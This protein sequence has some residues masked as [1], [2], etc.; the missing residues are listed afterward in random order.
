MPTDFA[1]LVQLNVELKLKPT[2]ITWSRLE[3]LALSRGDLTPGLQALLGDP[4]WLLGRQ[5]QFEELRGEDAGS[6]VTVTVR[7]EQAGVNRFHPGPFVPGGDAA[8]A[9][10]DVPDLPVEVAVEAEMPAVLPE[11]IRAEGG[12][13]L[14]RLVAVRGLPDGLRAALLTA[15]AFGAPEA[16]LG[17]VDPVGATRRRLLAGRVPDA[18]RIADDLAPLAGPDGALGGLPA[19]LAAASAGHE[20]AVRT[21]LGG[22][23]AGYRGIVAQPVGASWDPHRLEYAFALQAD[24]RDGPAVLRA[25]EYTDGRLDWYAFDVAATPGLGAPAAA[26]DPRPIEETVI[27]SPV[28]YAGMPSD[29]LWQ[30]EDGRVYLGG[31]EAGPTDLSRLA[32]TEFALV[33]GNDWYL[34]PV[35]MA[36]GS[37]VRIDSVVVRDTFGIETLVRPARQAQRP[38]WTVFHLAAH[39]EAGPLA[40]VFVLPATVRSVLESAPLEEVALFRDEMANL[41]W[42]VERVVQGPTGEPVPWDRLAARVSLRQRLPDDLGDA[43]LVYR[44]MTPVPENWIPF[45]AVPVRGQPAGSRATELERQPM[46]RFLDDGTT[47][48]VHPRGVVLRTA[49]DADVRTDRLRVAEEEVPRD[50]AVVTR[51]YQLARTEGGGTL[52]WIGRAKQAGQGEGASGL[53][54]DTALPPG[55]L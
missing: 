11:R 48:L 20:D 7:G 52:V 35:D 50:G 51:T 53:R 8:A 45:V 25:D 5:W 17:T 16:D 40:D 41:A 32:V 55:G 47:Q 22:W 19:T 24:L 30:F 43:G 1:K 37:V 23:L 9:S 14:L 44:L 39:A 54:F 29:R 33:F 18:A 34:A 15:Y 38:G 42:G 28:R 6:P 49:D 21:T 4:L 12:M 46:I 10:V 27:P 26:A 2:I 36:Y 31:L 3:P 13:Q